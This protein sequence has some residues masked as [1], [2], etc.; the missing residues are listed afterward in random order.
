M[1]AEDVTPA[2]APPLGRGEDPAVARAD[3][4]RAGFKFVRE[5]PVL[6]TSGDNP[7]TLVF[8]PAVRGKTDR[9]YYI[10]RKP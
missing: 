6:R 1:A 8:D 2:G 5:V 3:F 10:F 7:A 9:F 4:E